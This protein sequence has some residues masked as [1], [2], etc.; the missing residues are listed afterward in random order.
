[1]IW[2]GVF[3]LFY[4]KKKKIA[5]SPAK[6]FWVL[7]TSGPVFAARVC[8]GGPREGMGMRLPRSHCALVLS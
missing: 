8:S 2:F 4:K 6:V 7:A 1:M 5:V 3:L